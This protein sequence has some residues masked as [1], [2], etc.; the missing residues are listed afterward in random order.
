MI[1]ILLA[2][3]F[4]IPGLKDINI[5]PKVFGSKRNIGRQDRLLRAVIGTIALVLLIFVKK[6]F[7]I[8]YILGL[9]ALAGLV[10]A[11]AKFSPVYALIGENTRK[12]GKDE[13]KE[14]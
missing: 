7:L 10:T 8:R 2:R 9:T 11:Y 13:K 4:G 1:W 6:G 3:F 14:K 12:K 5:T